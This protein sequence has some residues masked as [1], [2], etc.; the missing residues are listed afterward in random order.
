MSIFECIIFECLTE[1]QDEMFNG[2]FKTQ[3]SGD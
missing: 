1:T 2:Q 3:G